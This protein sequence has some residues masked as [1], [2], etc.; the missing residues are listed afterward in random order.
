[1]S[2]IEKIQENIKYYIAQDY[3]KIGAIGQQKVRKTNEYILAGVGTLTMIII[4]YIVLNINTNFNKLDDFEDR[5]KDYQKG[6]A[7]SKFE[8]INL[9]IKIMPSYNLEKNIL[10]MRHSTDVRIIFYE[11]KLFILQT[12]K[13]VIKY[14]APLAESYKI[15]PSYFRTNRTRKVF[16][17]F[18]FTPDNVPLGNSIDM[19]IAIH[20]GLIER[21]KHYDIMKPVEGFPQC[22]SVNEKFIWNDDDSIYGIDV[23]A[24]KQSINEADCQSRECKEYCKKKFNGVYVEGVNKQ[25]CYSY[26]ILESICII[27]KYDKLR[28]EYVYHGGCYPGNKT[29]IMSPAQP[30]QIS[31]FSGVEIEV[32]ELSDPIV[33]AGELT[34]YEF[35]MGHSWRYLSIALKLI[36][37][38]CIG[39][40]TYVGYDIYRIRKK[41]KNDIGLVNGENNFQ[42]QNYGF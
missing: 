15:T 33:Q 39:L 26:D 28:D 13:S 8:K 41:Y 23:P 29:Y 4:F 18:S 3:F 22:A 24:W 31:D 20:W 25:V 21:G 7:A 37:I 34:N 1:M 2:K 40:L 12:A 32:R 11:K 38:F 19:C 9:G 16:P 36:S 42:S 35:N 27:I 17:I 6:I 30:E 10:Y 14:S 5:L